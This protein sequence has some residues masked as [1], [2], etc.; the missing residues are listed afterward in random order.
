MSSLTIGHA[1][2][3][4]GVGTETIRFYERKGLIARPS[5][6][7][8]GGFRSYSDAHVDRLR[9]IRSAQQ[10]GFSLREI[11]ELLS[12]EADANADCKEV[13]AKASRKLE[14]VELKIRR[15]R[16]VRAALKTVV[17]TCPKKGRA[18]GRCTILQA[19]N[20]KTSR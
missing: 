18:A 5:R 10:L 2:K 15:L 1:A 3:K 13:H 4:A 6:P 17:S 11:G 16:A 20:P 12:L 14:E 19:L 7:R 8:N 9:F